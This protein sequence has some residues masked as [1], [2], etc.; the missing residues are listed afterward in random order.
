MPTLRRSAALAAALCAFAAH[1]GLTITTEMK[2]KGKA[3]T[4][5]MQFEGK[6]LRSEITK[7]GSAEPAGAF[8]SDGDNKKILM[9]DYAKKEYHEITQEQMKRMKAKLEM[10]MAT[11]KSQMA[12]LPPEQ[13]K[14][15]EAVLGRQMNLS[16]AMATAPDEKYTRASGSK[17]IAGY[18]CD[19]YT[20]EVGGQHTADTCLI[21]WSDLKVDRD[22][23]KQ[24]VEA[25]TDVWSGMG[26]GGMG[27]AQKSPGAMLKAWGM[28]HGLPAWRKTVKADED[29]VTETTLKTITQG[30]IPRSAFDPPAGYT[31]APDKLDKE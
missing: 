1:A 3:G 18:K 24:S 21:P 11:M 2:K 16:K 28:S 7:D 23:F 30:A 14:Q 12:K 6:N 15:M 26:M 9:I 10:A 25:V 20:V 4:L 8:V 27:M 17:T 5:T 31:K 19:L 29:E 22:Q 13:R